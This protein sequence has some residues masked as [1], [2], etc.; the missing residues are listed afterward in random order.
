[1]LTATAY[2][3]L[4]L[5]LSSNPAANVL[6]NVTELSPL[7][8]LQVRA[9][10]VPPAAAFLLFAVHQQH[11]QITLSYQEPRLPR[12]KGTY[13]TGRDVGLV[14]L[15]RQE[16]ATEAAVWLTNDSHET[17]KVFVRTSWHTSSGKREGK[18]QEESQLQLSLLHAKSE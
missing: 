5:V 9:L 13:V 16:N 4:D 17:I 7:E 10:A 18:S 3:S 1:M 6:S 2:E 14:V 15:L 8:S 11:Q 12:R